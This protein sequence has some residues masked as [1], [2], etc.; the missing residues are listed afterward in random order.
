MG[1]KVRP[2]DVTQLIAD[3]YDDIDAGHMSDA[4][5]KLQQLREKLGDNDQNVLDAQMSYDLESL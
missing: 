4:Q 5:K 2:Q 3:F 1:T